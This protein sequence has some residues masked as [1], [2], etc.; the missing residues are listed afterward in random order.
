[1]QKRYGLGRVAPAPRLLLFVVLSTLVTLSN[2][3]ASVLVALGVGLLLLIVGRRYPRAAL[4]ACLSAFLLTFLGHALTADDP[5]LSF[6][7]FGVSRASALKGL[8]LGLRLAAMI[9][10]AIAFIAVTPLHELLEA[11]RGLRAPALVDIY[12]TIVL[13]YVDILW[14][15]IQTSMK[16][17]AVR[18]VNWEGSIRDKIPAFRRLM[19][20]LIFRILDHVDGQSLAIDNRGGV[21]VATTAPHVAEAAGALNMEGVYVFYGAGEVSENNHAISDLTLSVAR[22]GATVLLGAL[23]AGKTT[24]LLLSTGL[25]PKSVGRMKGDVSLF[26]RNTKEA[27]LAELG[28]LARI[29]FPSA[30]QGLV[31]LTVA[32]EL[33]FSLRAT[34]LRGPEAEEAMSGALR[35]VG[36]DASF[37]PRLTLSLSG[38]EMQRVALASAIVA[39][40]YLLALDDVTVQLDPVGKREVLAALQSL[41]GGEMTTI[42]TDPHVELLAEVG[43]RFVSLEGGRATGVRG[44]LE[45]GDL[46]KAGMRVP[47]LWRLARALDEDLPVA[48]GDAAAAL[49]PRAPLEAP[50]FTLAE[51]RERPPVVRAEDLTFTYPDG[52]TALQGLNLTLRKGEFVTVLGSNGSGK[53]T[54]ALLLAGALKPS[55][56]TVYVGGEPFDHRRH[57]GR[58]GYVFQEPVNQVVTMTVRDELAFGPQQLG[59]DA[60]ATAQAVDREMARFDL[61]A[62]AVPLHLSPADA[63]K[64][65]IA[66][67]LTMN[68]RLV[69]L[70]EPTNNLDEG[71]IHRLMRHLKQ[72]Q[73]EGTTVVVITHDVEV[74]CTYADRT[75]VMC[76]GK[77][78]LDG[79]TRAVMRQVDRLRESDV[80]PPPVVS[81]SLALWPNALPALTV[82]EMA[83]ALPRPAPG[84]T[85]PVAH[86]VHSEETTSRF[87]QLG[88]RR[89]AK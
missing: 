4:F 60:A 5:S 68:P 3:W 57:R 59:W 81:L 16:A 51:D 42:M 89:P 32:D 65:A 10:P 37:L 26:G 58:V 74:A 40:P 84:H 24:V 46:E 44:S 82:A 27:S 35:A 83:A 78:A 52:P 33:A 38:G 6:F 21:R 80:L 45:A 63:R 9:L 64:L 29:V 43:D 36:L 70:D 55:G 14:Y 8:R 15:D 22:G 49:A 39:R 86:R 1:M 54:T 12:L 77:V 61:H 41:L 23:G 71:E 53:T 69:I 11:F 20:P 75:V 30:V 56:G 73:A 13:R 28:R 47:Q 17:M 18:G 34:A 31:G 25:I 85:M 88:G 79:A 7:I 76:G 2:G 66:A 87:S 67:T 48:V 50:I 72:L 19:L 62:Q